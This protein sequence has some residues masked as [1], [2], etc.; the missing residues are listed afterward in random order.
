MDFDVYAG[1]VILKTTGGRWLGA[2]LAASAALTT[3]CT[4]SVDAGELPGVYRNSE[5]GGE[6]ELGSDGTFTATGISA[7]EYVGRGGADP[8]DFSGR[9][10]FLGDQAGSDFVYLAIETGGTGTI[11]GVQLYTRG[12]GKV[13][14]NP[15]PDGPPSLTLTEADT[16]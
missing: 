15:D 1:P 5:T 16:P 7:D 3:G 12:G 14:F 9:W 4:E 13:E 10:Q 2:V 11:G 6:I 8:V